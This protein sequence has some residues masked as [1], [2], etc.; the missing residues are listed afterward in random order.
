MEA[1]FFSSKR[2]KAAGKW[3]NISPL[4]LGCLDQPADSN[5][6]SVNKTPAFR[7]HIARRL[8]KTPSAVGG[9]KGKAPRQSSCRQTITCPPKASDKVGLVGVLRKE[10][11]MPTSPPKSLQPNR[12]H[13]TLPAWTNKDDHPPHSSQRPPYPD[14]RDRC[15]TT[16]QTTSHTPS[17][18]NSHPTSPQLNLKHAPPP[19]NATSAPTTS[20][21]LPSQH[22]PNARRTWMTADQDRTDVGQDT[23]LRQPPHPQP[24]PCLL[25]NREPSPLPHSPPPCPC[26]DQ[27]IPSLSLV[28]P[29]L[30][31]THQR[32]RRTRTGTGSFPVQSAGRSSR[33]PDIPAGRRPGPVN[34]KSP[35][36]NEAVLVSNRWRNQPQKQRKKE[37]L[38]ERK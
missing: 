4:W 18:Q 6:R 25:A 33:V 14:G 16:L 9:R 37:G 3:T 17:R 31:P 2:Y 11:A 1:I 21:T 10:V 13:S 20:S 5:G 15:A 8:P 24:L 27:S 12:Q 34:T 36:N 38:G 29:S 32:P 26:Q 23:S 28:F 7:S 19:P 30:R 22:P 35:V